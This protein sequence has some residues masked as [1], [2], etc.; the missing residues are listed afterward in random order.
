MKSKEVI[1]ELKI[2]LTKKLIEEN[3]D[4]L[5]NNLSEYFY[6]WCNRNNQTGYNNLNELFKDWLLKEDLKGNIKV[7]N[8]INSNKSANLGFKFKR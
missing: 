1:L 5:K 2:K 3:F 6:R 8:F 4:E 7:K